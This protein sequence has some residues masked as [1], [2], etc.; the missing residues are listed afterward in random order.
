LRI[1]LGL[2]VV[3]A[4]FSQSRPDPA[5]GRALVERGRAENA[6]GHYE[7]SRTYFDKAIR[8]LEECHTAACAPVLNDARGYQG[9]LLFTIGE[10]QAAG[11]ILEKV[12]RIP[13]SQM[14]K[15]LLIESLSAYS[16]I[17]LGTNRERE[18]VPY[19]ALRKSL[20][21]AFPNAIPKPPTRQ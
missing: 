1:P 12:T 17:L 2:L 8:Y 14:D 20:M 13:A 16:N 6:K 18:A 4:V 11:P 10:F 7:I 21:I 3:T 9:C 5:A 15:S 19:V